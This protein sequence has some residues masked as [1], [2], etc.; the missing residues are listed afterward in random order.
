MV[1]GGGLNGTTLSLLSADFSSQNI[2]IVAGDSYAFLLSG[3]STFALGGNS[4]GYAGGRQV[5]SNTGATFFPF[6]PAQDLY[7]TASLA[8]APVP[9]PSTYGLIGAV[10][11]FALVGLRMGHKRLTRSMRS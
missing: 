9:E 11:L 7:F 8:A 6:V 2:S 3:P 5:T 4:D 10:G 1:S